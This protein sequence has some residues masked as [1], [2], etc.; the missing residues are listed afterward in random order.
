MVP[1]GTVLCTRGRGERAGGRFIRQKGTKR[2]SIMIQSFEVGDRD[3]SIFGVP[4]KCLETEVE[5]A[6]PNGISEWHANGRQA[7]RRV[8][9]HCF[10][11]CS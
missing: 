6:Q 9:M 10:R 7:M 4:A 5:I 3:V 2:L 1:Y 11:S 8:A